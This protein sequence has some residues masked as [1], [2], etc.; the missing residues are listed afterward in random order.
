M[1]ETHGNDATPNNKP[2]T[3]QVYIYIFHTA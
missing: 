1:E 2:S 3:E